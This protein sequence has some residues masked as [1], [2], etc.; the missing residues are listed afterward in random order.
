MEPWRSFR[1]VP[2]MAAPQLA[3]PPAEAAPPAGVPLMAS[4]LAQAQAWRQRPAHLAEA[5]PP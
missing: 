1:R 5:S 3:A 2:L 4:A